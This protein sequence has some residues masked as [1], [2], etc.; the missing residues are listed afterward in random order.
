[1]WGDWARVPGAWSQESPSKTFLREWGRRG[2]ADIS[3][4]HVGGQ[5]RKIPAKGGKLTLTASLPPII[6]A[7]KE[8]VKRE[9]GLWRENPGKGKE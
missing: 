5:R 4:K 2:S 8:E 6:S 1:V 3:R 9:Q 7:K